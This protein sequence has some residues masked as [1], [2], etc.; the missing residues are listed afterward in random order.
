RRRRS[1]VKTNMAETT[2]RLYIGGL[3]SPVTEA[4]LKQ[5]FQAFGTVSDVEIPA[6]VDGMGRARGFAHL[7]LTGTD[8]SFRRCVSV[9]N[10]T[11]WAGMQLKIEE[12]KPSRLDR[13]EK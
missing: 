6:A 2:R 7:T 1:P 4:Q 13:L 10:G 3:T 5:R 12:A 11:K 9:Y 8:S